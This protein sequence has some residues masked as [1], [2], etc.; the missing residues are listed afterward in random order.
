MTGDIIAV[1]VANPPA[2]WNKTRTSP[3]DGGNLARSFPGVEHGSP[4]QV[5]AFHLGHAVIARADF[6]LDLHSSGVKLLMPSM[7]GFAADDRRSREAAMIFGAPVVWA[8]R[9]VSPGRTISFSSALD[10]PWLYTEARGAG[11]I[12]PDDLEMFKVGIRNLLRHL[13]ILAGSP[14][15]APIE[16]FLE[17]D[18]DIDTSITAS[19]RG[20]FI[21]T[22][23]LLQ[24]VSASQEIGRTV[25]EYG[26]V[27]ERFSSPRDGV[28][29]M[30]H[31]FPVIEP[32]ES[33]FLITGPLQ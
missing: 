11:R 5:I 28:V 29:G 15:S 7:V 31:V 8:H 6:Y 4:T 9:T 14:D 17:G 20:F 16:H 12:A 23:S 2:L 33:I 10:I 18:G 22:V 30:I 27:V 19:Q 32:G 13:F 1:P 26:E 21:P 24:T 25:N 3:L